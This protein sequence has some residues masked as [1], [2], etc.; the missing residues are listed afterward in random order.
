MRAPSVDHTV[1]TENRP[2][3]AG[4]IMSGEFDVVSKRRLPF[5]DVSEESDP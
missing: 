1:A 2:Q 5:S 3:D 4:D